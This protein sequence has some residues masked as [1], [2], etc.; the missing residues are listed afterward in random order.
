MAISLD[1]RGRTALASLVP[2][3]DSLVAVAPGEARPRRDSAAAL[4]GAA[5]PSLPVCEPADVEHALV[6]AREAQPAW[7]GAGIETRRRTLL[8]F[9]DLVWAMHDPMLDLIQYENGKA[10]A[11]AFEELADVA[12]TARYYAAT[13]KKHLKERR[14]A[15]AVPVLTSTRVRHPARGVVAVIAP[16]NYPLTLVVSDA[17]AALAAGNAVII[18]PDNHTPY[19]A[20]AGVALLREAGVPAEIVQVVLGSGATL[21]PSLVGGADYAMFTGSTE[22]GRSVAGL[23]GQALVPVSAEL[24]GKNPMIV[25]EDA[26]LART[27]PGAIKACFSNAGQ[28]CISIERIYVH[29]RIW[30]RFVPAFA[31]AAKKLRVGASFDWNLGMGPL[32]DAERL[33]EVSRDVNEAVAAGAR[34]LAGGRALAEVSPTAYA[35]TVLTDVPDGVRLAREETFGP[36]VSLYRV[37]DDDEAVALANDS[38]YGLNASVWTGSAARGREIAARLRCGTVNV[39]EGYAASW[40]STDAPMGGMG[41][42]GLGRRH[43]AEGIVKYTQPQTVSV[44]RLQS[45]QAPRVLSERGWARLLRTYLRARRTLDR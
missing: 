42:S 31:D 8:R 40:A 25:C 5:M 24:G 28:L 45:I 2:D 33:A 14:A 38:H 3:P 29:E 6:R 9:H 19:T 1:D 34:V 35:P 18:K 4:T 41:A 7:E 32:V 37:A 44:Q 13:A 12:M 26:S 15:G 23:A 21:A 43:G 22:A 39:N 10:R 30:D 20:L 27:V 16:W 17:V 11:H 36:V